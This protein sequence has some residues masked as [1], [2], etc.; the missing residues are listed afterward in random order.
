MKSK[1]EACPPLLPLPLLRG[2]HPCLPLTNA[3][4]ADATKKISELKMQPPE[5][6]RLY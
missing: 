2:H 1:E 5:K 6:A 3:L 4:N